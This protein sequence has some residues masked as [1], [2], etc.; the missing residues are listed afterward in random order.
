VSPEN[1]QHFSTIALCDIGPPR[2]R[3]ALQQVRFILCVTTVSSRFFSG[4]VVR[5]LLDN[6]AINQ[7]ALQT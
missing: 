1:G 7:F 4:V 5:R 6:V 3:I 2:D